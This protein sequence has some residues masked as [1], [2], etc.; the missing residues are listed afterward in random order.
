MSNQYYY[1]DEHKKPQGPV[2]LDELLKKCE[3]GE[4]NAQ[5]LV[6]NPGA[7][8]WLPLCRLDP[9]N[10]DAAVGDCPN[11]HKEILLENTHLPQDCPSCGM[12]IRPATYGFI[13]CV[14]LCYRKYA[15]FTGR[16][17]RAE[18]WFFTLF[19]VIV[20]MA[21]G[22][23]GAIGLTAVLVAK[24]KNGI[25]LDVNDNTVTLWAQL[26]IFL[27]GFAISGLPGLAVAVRRLH[28]IG[29]SG[30][31]AIINYILNMFPL[32]VCLVCPEILSETSDEPGNLTMALLM[33]VLPWLVNMILSIIL[34]VLSCQDS[35][36][37]ANKYGVSPKY[38]L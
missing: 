32:C 13:D 23:F 21:L 12:P 10:A 25:E 14:K 28:D 36:R 34:V 18:Y 9:K 24:F 8:E 26:I 16:A 7:P 30:C 11:C 4:L 27:I 15:V 5:T 6:A 37:G 3:A 1:L 29:V 2:E 31:W 35:H 19:S 22:F 38:P 33:V 20:G 17:P